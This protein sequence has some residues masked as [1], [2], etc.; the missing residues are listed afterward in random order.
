MIK[1]DDDKFKF[2]FGLENQSNLT[3]DEPKMNQSFTV[4]GMCELKV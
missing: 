1:F 3:K 2:W 4:F